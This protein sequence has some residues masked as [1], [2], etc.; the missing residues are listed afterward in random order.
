[1]M[2]GKSR[3]LWLAAGLLVLFVLA[4]GVCFAR[5][6][7]RDTPEYALA[8]LAAGIE[9][10]DYDTVQ[11]YADVD[12]LVTS[13]YDESTEILARDIE[14]LHAL[15]PEDWF[16]RHDTAFMKGYIAD[17]RAQDLQLIKDSLAQA[18]SGRRAAGSR[19]EA[20]FL[21]TEAGKFAQAYRASVRSVEKQDGKAVAVIDVRS[22]GTSD[23]GRLLPDGLTLKL[24]MEQQADGRYRVVQVENVSELFYPVTKAVE[25]YWTLQG[26]Q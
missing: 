5:S 2:A 25:D 24:G 26:W 20:D 21:S 22:D 3:R 16:F 18:V 6:M 9:N 7:A 12:R 4:G 10:K 17:R 23:Y 1:M 13:S 14:K 8:Q 11:R 19:P 15:Y